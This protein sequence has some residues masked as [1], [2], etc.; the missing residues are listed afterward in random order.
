MEIRDERESLIFIHSDLDDMGLNAYEFRIYARLARR[1]GKNGSYES[2]A[3]MAEG[4]RIGHNTVRDAL[5]GLVSRRM[6][7][8]IDRSGKTPVYVLTKPDKW[9]SGPLPDQVTPTG[10][11][12]PP[13]PDQVAPP[14]PDQVTEGT[15][16]EGTPKKEREAPAQFS[17]TLPGNSTLTDSPGYTAHFSSPP[18]RHK[19]PDRPDSVEQV[20]Q[21]GQ[22]VMV[23]ETICRAFFDYYEALGWYKQGN[24]DSPIHKWKSQ[25]KVYYN[26][27]AQFNKKATPAPGVTR[28]KI[29]DQL[30]FT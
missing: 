15:P 29:Q 23:P 27:E 28:Q 6:V 22:V 8:R 18:P 13:L 2:V 20:V 21:Y 26:K 30:R 25:L 9:I 4:C 10:S 7:E 12:N 17:D 19:E 14:L 1:A 11:G 3:N 5:R 16:I 24:I